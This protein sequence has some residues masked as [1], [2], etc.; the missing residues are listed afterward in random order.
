MPPNLSAGGTLS[1]RSRS[2]AGEL[3]EVRLHPIDLGYKQPRSQKGRPVMAKGEVANAVLD[4]FKQLSLPFGTQIEIQDNVG[5][6]RVTTQS[7]Y[8]QD[9]LN[10]IGE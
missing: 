1:H 8:E 7:S 6:I 4:L 5:V 10:N 9:S 2:K 3:E